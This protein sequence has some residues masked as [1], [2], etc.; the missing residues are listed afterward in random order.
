MYHIAQRWLA[1]HRWRCIN[2]DQPW[3]IGVMVAIIASQQ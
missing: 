2:N 3:R 1:A